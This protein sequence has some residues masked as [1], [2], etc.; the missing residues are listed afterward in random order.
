MQRVRLTCRQ[1]LPTPG[2]TGPHTPLQ[3]TLNAGF[4]PPGNKN[5][6]LLIRRPPLP[7]IMGMNE[8]AHPQ[9]VSIITSYDWI[10]LSTGLTAC[11]Y[12][13]AMLFWVA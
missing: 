1:G 12:F 2:G 13:I 8:E 7:V 11:V 3:C 9:P 5:A 6:G 4:L 10:V